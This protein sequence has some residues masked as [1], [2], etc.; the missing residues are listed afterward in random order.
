MVNAIT[1]SPWGIQLLL[2][3]PVDA[4]KTDRQA[5][6]RKL[7]KLIENQRCLQERFDLSRLQNEGLEVQKEIEEQRQT[8][9]GR[10]IERGSAVSQSRE[11]EKKKNAPKVTTP[12]M[13]WFST[14]GNGAWGLSHKKQFIAKPTEVWEIQNLSMCQIFSETNC[15]VSGL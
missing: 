3:P 5:D 15:A 8:E 4:Q 13:R 9:K 10:E 6:N 11:R 12:S 7:L 14:E 2:P 1:L